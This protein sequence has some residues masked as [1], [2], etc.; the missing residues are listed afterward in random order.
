MRAK[1]FARFIPV[2]REPT[3]PGWVVTATSVISVGFIFAS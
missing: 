3:R 2:R 1:V